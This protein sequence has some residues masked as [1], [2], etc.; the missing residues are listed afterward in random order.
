M[1]KK[2]NLKDTPFE[3]VTI[4]GESFGVMG[5]YRV[6]EKYEKSADVKKE[7]KRITWNRLIQVVMILD[8]IK[9][10]YNLKTSKK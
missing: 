3:V 2:E 9:S 6:T 7:L 1:I 10:K 4:N 5:D 8:E